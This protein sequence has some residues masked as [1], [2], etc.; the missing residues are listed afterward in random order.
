[1]LCSAKALPRFRVVA[2]VSHALHEFDPHAQRVYE[3]FG[4]V[5]NLFVA[6]RGRLSRGQ[7]K[8]VVQYDPEYGYPVVADMDPREEVL[9]DELYFRVT[10]F[11]PLELRD[12]QPTSRCN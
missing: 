5:D 1:M 7:Y 11:R 9:D 4:T 6:I 2:G 8:A 12:R 3:S 10:E